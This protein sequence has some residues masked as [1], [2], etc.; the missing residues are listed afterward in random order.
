MTVEVGG[1]IYI[2]N[3]VGDDIPLRFEDADGNQKKV[4]EMKTVKVHFAMG[5]VNGY[6]DVRKTGKVIGV[7]FVTMPS[8]RILMS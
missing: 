8:I 3:H 1:L 4:I 7:P 2:L 6:F 5:K